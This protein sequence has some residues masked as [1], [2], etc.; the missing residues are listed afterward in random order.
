ME[1][2]VLVSAYWHY[3]VLVNSLAPHKNQEHVM[4]RAILQA[5]PGCQMAA[6]SGHNKPS[7]T[8]AMAANAVSKSAVRWSSISCFPSNGVDK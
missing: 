4:T 8:E 5:G 3:W 1:L 6:C 2:N 7:V